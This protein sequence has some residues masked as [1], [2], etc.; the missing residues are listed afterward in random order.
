MGTYTR[1]RDWVRNRWYEKSN[2]FKLG[3]DGYLEHN[4]IL[5]WCNRSDRAHNICW[6]MDMWGIP[7]V[8]TRVMPEKKTLYY[9][10]TYS[11]MGDLTTPNTIWGRISPQA[12]NRDRDTPIHLL[13]CL[14]C[15]RIIGLRQSRDDYMKPVL[16]ALGPECFEHIAELLLDFAACDD[17]GNGGKH[18]YWKD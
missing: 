12:Y 15:K 4:R 9:Y 10:G 13:P 14:S 7:I 3:P 11:R 18:A 1:R 5:K 16:D 6:V 17:C 8:G 2:N